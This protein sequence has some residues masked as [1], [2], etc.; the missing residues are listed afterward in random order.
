MLTFGAKKTR[1]I[2]RTL[3]SSSVFELQ[4]LWDENRVQIHGLRQLEFT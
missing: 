1:A 4:F 2:V 3:Q